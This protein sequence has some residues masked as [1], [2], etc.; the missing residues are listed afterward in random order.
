MKRLEF[1]ITEDMLSE[2][3]SIQKAIKATR[4]ALDDDERR[5]KLPP[6]VPTDIPLY[7]GDPLPFN[8]LKD[9]IE[10]LDKA[11]FLAQTDQN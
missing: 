11:I 5:S 1:E 6:V 3:P 7:G 4:K 2:P 10:D 8:D 9:R